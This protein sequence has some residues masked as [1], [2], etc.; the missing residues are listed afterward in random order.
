MM[1]GTAIGIIFNKFL[2]Y[3]LIEMNFFSRI[4]KSGLDNA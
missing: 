4:E 2:D 1:I 3:Q